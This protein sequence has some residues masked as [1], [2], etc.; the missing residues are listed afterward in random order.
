MDNPLE[1]PLCSVLDR[2][3]YGYLKDD[4][5]FWFTVSVKGRRWKTII[6]PGE[7]V[8]TCFSV[9]PWK[10]ASNALP[11]MRQ[12][13]DEWNRIQQVGCFFINPADFRLIYRYSVPVLDLFSAEDYIAKVLRS[14]AAVTYAYWERVFQLA[15]S[16]NNCAG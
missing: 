16:A 5:G 2:R 15:G 7:Q 1:Q 9:Y 6:C 10:I 13:T 3:G 14:S 11:K 12:Q 4:N 8:I